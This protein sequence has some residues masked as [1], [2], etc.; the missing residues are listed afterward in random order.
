M[1]GGREFLDEGQQLGDVRGVDLLD[2]F[3]EGLVA[4][5][6]A[7]ANS[8]L[9]R[10]FDFSHGSRLDARPRP[11]PDPGGFGRGLMAGKR[12]PAAGRGAV[13]GEGA[14]ADPWASRAAR[15]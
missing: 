8:L 5:A 7:H 1:V 13:D 15:R 3:V 10:R 6:A 2:E 12:S 11:V 14:V 4:P 9:E